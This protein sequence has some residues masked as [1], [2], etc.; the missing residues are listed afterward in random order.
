LGSPEKLEKKEK[1]GGDSPQ[2]QAS[3][4][5]TTKT[6]GRPRR[7]SVRKVPSAGVS[8]GTGGEVSRT[9]DHAQRVVGSASNPSNVHGS[10]ITPQASGNLKISESDHG[11]TTKPSRKRPKTRTSTGKVPPIIG[12][13][14]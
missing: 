11:K 4:L 9:R 10:K 1:T 2:Y 5:K 12:K 13:G 6:R 8:P 7:P 14:Y 3:I